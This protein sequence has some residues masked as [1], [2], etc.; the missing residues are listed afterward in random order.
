MVTIKDI[1]KEFDID[2][3]RVLKQVWKEKISISDANG[4]LQLRIHQYANELIREAVLEFEKELHILNVKYPDGLPLITLLN[5][6][7]EI[8][9]DFQEQKEK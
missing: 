3:N 1:E 4:Y 6:H 7:K 8:F 9:G 2:L 5:K